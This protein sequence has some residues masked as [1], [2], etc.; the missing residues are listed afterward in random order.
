MSKP[1]RICLAAL[2]ALAALSPP[3]AAGGEPEEPQA[4]Q[5]WRIE[6]Q[7]VIDGDLDDPAW[8]AVGQFHSGPFIQ[9]S[10][11]NGAPSSQKTEIRIAYTD[12]AIY[13]GAML[14]DEEPGQI[15]REFGIR[16][17]GERNSDMFA[18]AFDTYDKQQNAFAFLVS[19]AGV[20]TDI[21]L[22]PNGD[23][24]SWNAVW[25]SAVKIHDNGWAVEMEIPYS[26]LR[27]AKQ[28]EQVWGINFQRILKRKQETAFWNHVDA[29]V[30]GLVNQFGKLR[31]LRGIA[32]PPRIQ[33][34]PY[35]SGYL[36]K[37]TDG[38][39]SSSV[40]GG[41]DLKLGLSE[42]FTLDMSLV[43]DFGQV[44]ADNVV[45]NLSPFEVMFSENRPFF[46]EGTDLFNRGGMFYSRRIGQSFAEEDDVRRRYLKAHPDA[47]P[48]QLEIVDMPAG[49]VPNTAPLVNATKI[50]GR[51]KSGLGIGFFNAVTNKT[52]ATLRDYGLE[53]GLQEQRVVADP[54]TNFNVLVID[55]NLPNNSNVGIINTNVTRADGGRDA[56]ATAL[57]FRL[58]DK[59]NRYG[60]RGFGAYNRIWTRSV[61][62]E[63][64][65]SDGYKYFLEVGKYSGTW[66]FGLWRNVESDD[67][68]IRDMGFLRAPNEFTHGMNGSYNI[69]QPF[70][71]F[72]RLSVSAG[73][74]H[75]QLFA[76]RRFATASAWSSVN[77]Q[78][79]N[80]WN[81][82]VWQEY[83]ANSN[84][85]FEPRTDDFS[86]HFH[87]RWSHSHNLWWG[88][89]SRKR[90]RL[91]MYSGF[92]RRPDWGQFDNWVGL[93]PRFRVNNKLSFSHGLE[94]TRI[95]K[96]PGYIWD[97]PEAFNPDGRVPFGV[98]DRQ[99]TV[100]T[101]STDY[102]FND[103]MGLNLR[104]RHY[105]SKVWYDES[106]FSFLQ[107]DGSLMPMGNQYDGRDAEGNSY[108]D[109][110]FNA[111]NVDLS[112]S[113]QF[114]PGS[115]MT[116]VWKQ[117][118]YDENGQV[119][120]NFSRNLSDTWRAPQTNSLSVRILYF[121]D[122]LD[123]KK[124]LR[125]GFAGRMAS[126]EG[127]ARTHRNQPLF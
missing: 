39:V 75:E 103:R 97:V 55:Q 28:D 12:F 49:G 1:F 115:M 59:K 35:V 50:S 56:N 11:E 2:A 84:D 58:N 87:R 60:A 13:V 109:V 101:F 3:A 33:F 44:V 70:G 86:Q 27:F 29:S 20:Q 72:L 5:A 79:K 122:Y 41:M 110:N 119:G 112:Y 45:F 51:T 66:Q 92:W 62:D 18:V 48:E 89:D 65:V 36:V 63:A 37:G 26:A 17:S 82:N 107:E 4:I 21:F 121:L 126:G 38:Q 108:H 6:G 118:I 94:I 31:G 105:W 99:E 91:E 61:A 46:T 64:Q 124:V 73:L 83:N 52:Y 71:K 120:K 25:K 9:T 111:F 54:L 95:R 24:V 8:Q 74:R 23:D 114:A 22:T 43:P 106:R 68:N 81:F 40:N 47:D 123:V 93:F 57:D 80:F 125:Q 127:W 76:P 14:F 7:P 53:E 90:F 15:L 85:F 100:N 116:V 113:W 69:F 96:E 30:N 32:P 10:P 104:V 77:G 19:A 16:D 117:T 67:Y 42:S 78:F 102:I 98:R 88:T 34:T